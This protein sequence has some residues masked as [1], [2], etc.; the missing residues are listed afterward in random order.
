M[1]TSNISRPLTAEP[2]HTGEL[3]QSP[4]QLDPAASAALA[5]AVKNARQEVDPE[6][7]TTPSPAR[8]DSA[9]PQMAARTSSFKAL[10]L[11]QAA[12][13]LLVVGAGWFASHA[14]T[15]ANQD[16]IRRMET[17][18]ARSQEIL[19]KLTEDLAALKSTMAA[20]QD[21]E[22]TSSITSASDQA[23]IAEKVDRLAVAIQEPGQKL[24]SLEDRLGRMESQIMA[25]LNSLNA[26][27]PAAPATPA[28]PPAPPVAAPA[29]APAAA[30][31]P[32]PEPESAPAVKPARTDTK[33]DAKTDP[34]DGWVLREVYNGSALVES[35]SRGLYEVM[36]GNV[37]PGAGRVESIE[38]RGA[39][40]VVITD[41]GLIGAYR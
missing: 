27:K 12:T 13:A 2:G 40:W 8:P 3:A 29:A 41:K 39:R 19:A 9:E 16:V 15:Q 22:Q 11:A 17:E 33:T 25:G 30:S 21:V 5:E 1:D 28:T 18:A 37:I 31:A 7:K 14:G 35:R 6:P 38:R 4:V 34:V 20:A 23:R 26:A 10:F 32:Q 36:P 24:S